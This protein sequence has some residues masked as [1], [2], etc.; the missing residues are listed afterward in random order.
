[1]GS[2]CAMDRFRSKGTY[3]LKKVGFMSRS[4]RTATAWKRRSVSFH[5]ESLHDC[6]FNGSVASAVVVV[7]SLCK[8]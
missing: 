5:L 3:V 6:R 7:L 4:L 8:R 2:Y 1:M